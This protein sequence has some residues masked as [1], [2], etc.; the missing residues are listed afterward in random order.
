MKSDYINIFIFKEIKKLRIFQ[1]GFI[2]K[3]IIFLRKINHKAKISKINIS[4]KLGKC[5]NIYS[6]KFL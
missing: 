5:Y 4:I 2:L 1:L 3:P 6:I